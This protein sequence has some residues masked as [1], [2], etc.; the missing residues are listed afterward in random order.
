MEY[1]YHYTAAARWKL[2]KKSGYLKLTPSNLLKPVAPHWEVDENGVR[3]FVDETDSY[4]PVVW[5][6]NSDSP[7]GHAVGPIKEQLQIAIPYNKDKHSWWVEWKDKNRMNKSWFKKLTS[8]GERY[9]TWYVSEEIIPLEEVAWV[10]DLW[11]GK[12]LYENKKMKKNKK[13]G[14][15]KSHNGLRRIFG[16][17]TPSRNNDKSENV[18]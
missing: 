15:E 17:Y 11:S 7:K 9:G 18:A 1:V 14:L 13:L 2:I 6:T 10:K 16:T 5:L 4:K 8:R 3:N 12:I